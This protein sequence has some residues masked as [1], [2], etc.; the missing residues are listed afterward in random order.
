MTGLKGV[1]WVASK[2]NC[3]TR[4]MLSCK[5]VKGEPFEV[6]S[7]SPLAEVGVTEESN[8]DTVLSYLFEC[9]PIK[10]DHLDNV[11]A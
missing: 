5:S 2:W 7:K 8:L 4:L 11:V 9:F 1:H 6:V 10:F 3:M